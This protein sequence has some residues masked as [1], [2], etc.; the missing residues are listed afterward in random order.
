MMLKSFSTY[1]LLDLHFHG[2]KIALLSFLSGGARSVHQH[3][4]NS[5]TV[6][7]ITFI[8]LTTS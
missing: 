5:N 3:R 1:F 2:V 6:L 8:F 7:L 4:Y